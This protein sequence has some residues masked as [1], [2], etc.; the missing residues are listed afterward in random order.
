MDTGDPISIQAKDNEGKGKEKIKKSKLK[1]GADSD[2]DGEHS[3]HP[4]SN[5]PPNLFCTLPSA[6]SPLP[7]QPI[8][9]A[10]LH[11][12]VAE[13][14]I[15]NG[16]SLEDYQYLHDR[17]QIESG[18]KD[19]AAASRSDG[20]AANGEL[21][22]TRNGHS[23][24]R[25][26]L[27]STETILSNN[28]SASNG[29]LASGDSTLL[30]ASMDQI[31][32]SSSSPS[33][34]HSISS[35]N[36][37]SQHHT[38]QINQGEPSRAL[39]QPSEVELEAPWFSQLASLPHLRS[40]GIP[41]ISPQSTSNPSYKGKE[42]MMNGFGGGGGGL[43]LNPDGRPN[44]SSGSGITRN[45]SPT[46][47]HNRNHH[48]TSMSV[49]SSPGGGNDF[50]PRSANGISAISNQ[51]Q[52]FGLASESSLNFPSHQA[53]LS[54]PNKVPIPK[55]IPISQALNLSAEESLD[56]PLLPPDNFSMVNTWVYRSSFPK[57]KHFPFLKSLG[58][59]SVL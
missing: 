18:G 13:N 56:E 51:F 59:R 54:Q 38:I 21:R 20:S 58:L 3:H 35:N 44:T 4:A 57:K 31:A 40:A 36:A 9:L 53:F 48:P 33:L 25:E 37:L 27:A 32:S 47:N 23:D 10:F 34:D 45:N 55:P 50:R 2:S 1:K 52:S 39:P 11:R 5:T 15:K 49:Q 12:I 19:D 6:K 28:G 14:R 26:R 46:N 22:G 30:P 24:S 43:N 8:P 41:A 29:N 16:L 42:K 7:T 17:I